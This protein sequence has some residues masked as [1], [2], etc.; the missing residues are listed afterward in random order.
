V[1][2]ST[3]KD[4]TGRDWTRL[5]ATGGAIQAHAH[6]LLHFAADS[7]SLFENLMKT[8]I[9]I[10][11]AMRAYLPQFCRDKIALSPRKLQLN[12]IAART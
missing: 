3:L 5:D 11:L 4:A 9:N 10:A 12:T 6:R 2:I 1:Y 7:I 8:F